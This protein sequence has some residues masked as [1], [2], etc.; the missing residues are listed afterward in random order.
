M[1]FTKEESIG[2]SEKVFKEL[3][4]IL[5]KR[6]ESNPADTL[7]KIN[8]SISLLGLIS[9]KVNYSKVGKKRKYTKRPKASVDDVSLTPMEL[10]LKK[11]QPSPSLA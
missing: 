5:R 6:D 4:S 11:D 7:D 8:K 10:P 1:K 2:L 3:E 9:N